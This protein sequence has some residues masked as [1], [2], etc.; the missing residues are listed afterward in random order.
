MQKT[1]RLTNRVIIISLICVYHGLTESCF[2][3]IWQDF[4][5]F[6]EIKD[7]DNRTIWHRYRTR[8]EFP[9]VQVWDIDCKMN[10]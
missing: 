5:V 10:R 7:H 2:E 1:N 4:L 9:M 8:S 3:K 6:G